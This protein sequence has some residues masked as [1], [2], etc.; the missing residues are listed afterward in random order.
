LETFSAH[1]D[2]VPVQ[3]PRRTLHKELAEAEVSTAYTKH[4]IFEQNDGTE[5]FGSVFHDGL[6]A[7]NA[8]V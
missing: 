6:T 5:L 4:V 2:I 8:I 1:A 7:R 3:F